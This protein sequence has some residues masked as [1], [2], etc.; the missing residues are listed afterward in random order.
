MT[1]RE[2]FREITREEIKSIARKHM[3]EGG[4]NSLSLNAIAREMDM[5]PS[6]LYRYFANRN[7]LLTALIIDAYNSLNGAMQAASDS[8]P[9]DA[10]GQRLLAIVLAYR[11][12]VLENRAEFELLYGRP[13]KDFQGLT[14]E[15]IRVARKGF[16]LIVELLNEADD[17]GQIT[18]SPE[19]MAVAEDVQVTIQIF[20]PDDSYIAPAHIAYIGLTGLARMQGLIILEVTDQI[21]Y[22]VS[23]PDKLYRQ[24]MLLL[25]RQFGLKL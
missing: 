11:Q 1:R 9:R 22:F 17:A 16:T 20:L 7:E 10:Y 18:L 19:Q 12:W 2:K 4:V 23:D 3:Q 15:V 14:D 21:Q 5:V 25:L 24:E 6:A 8:H 13:V